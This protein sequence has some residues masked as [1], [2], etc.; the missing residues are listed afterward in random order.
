M[1][2]PAQI[3]SEIHKGTNYS[4]NKCILLRF[5]S[6]R[7]D[8]KSFFPYEPYKLLH[9]PTLPDVLFFNIKRSPNELGILVVTLDLA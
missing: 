5:F 4:T 2:K 9:Y 3:A 7:E 8:K 1:A 6:V